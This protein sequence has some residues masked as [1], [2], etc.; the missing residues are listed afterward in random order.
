MTSIILS[1]I[2]LITGTQARGQSTGAPRTPEPVGTERIAGTVMQ[3]ETQRPFPRVRVELR[4][5]DYGR[6][7]SGGEKPC[8]P[9]RD[10]DDPKLHRYAMTD[11]NGHFTFQNVVPGR[12]YL[13]AEHEGYLRTEYG[14][15]DGLFPRGMIL[16]IGPQDDTLLSGTVPLG[17]RGGPFVG[18]VETA[19]P[20]R[21]GMPASV[22]QDLVL[23]LHPAPT[24]IGRVYNEEGARVPAAI[25][26]LYQYRFAPM[27]GRTLKPVRSIFT[28]D[29]GEYRLFWLNPGRY[30]VAA[31]YSDYVLQPWTEALRFTPNLPDGDNRYPVVFYPG[32]EKPSEA[33]PVAMGTVTAPPIDVSLW[34]RPR[35]NVEIKLVGAPA[36]RNT[37]VALVPYGGDLCAAMDYAITPSKDGV[38]LIRDVPAGP[39]LVMAVSGRDSLSELRPLNVDQHIRDYP[40]TIIPPVDIPVTVS[41]PPEGIR[42]NLTRTG[43]EVSHVAAAERDSAGKFVFK[44]VGPGSYYVTADSPPGYYLEG[45][46]AYQLVPGGDDGCTREPNTTPSRIPSSNYRY[47][48]QHGHL[49]RGSPLIVPG[50]IPG[51]VRCVAVTMRL[52]GRLYGRAVDRTGTP[53]TGALVVGLPRSVW[54]ADDNEVSFTPPDRFLS[55]TTDR[56]GRFVLVGAVPGTEYKLFAFEDIDTNLIYDP[57]LMDRFPNRDLMDIEEVAGTDTPAQRRAQQLRG[58]RS[59]TFSGFTGPCSENVQCILRAIS[60]EE[61]RELS[62]GRD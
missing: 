22:L 61:T 9:S 16:E 62:M 56:E 43:N 49:N 38:V 28:D 36:P 57:D 13:L 29:N 54:G 45:A 30:V 35:F 40:L 39:Y 19:R 10:I 23:R 46:G 25:V 60:A 26:Q 24:I 55:A 12:Y 32:V 34:K 44:G 14:R 48:D 47:L 33:F 6:Q 27:N 17:A 21:P 42:F 5:E 7:L 20:T 4:R 41:S 50:I 1:L 15:R 3:G 52:G 51:E 58:I 31:S 53:V 18:V 37:T 2:L 59:V 8:N 11:T